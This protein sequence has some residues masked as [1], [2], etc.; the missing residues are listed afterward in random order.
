MKRQLIT[1]NTSLAKRISPHRGYQQLPI[2]SCIC[3]VKEPMSTSNKAFLTFTKTAKEAEATCQAKGI[4]LCVANSMLTLCFRCPP[5]VRKSYTSKRYSLYIWNPIK[6]KIKPLQIWIPVGQFSN[7]LFF[8]TCFTE[9]SRSECWSLVGVFK[10]PG[11]GGNLLSTQNQIWGHFGRI[12]L[13][14]VAFGM[15]SAFWSQ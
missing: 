6:S 2:H 14:Q 13:L 3:L 4:S 8:Q 9:F 1:L 7:K 10:L 12:P 11:L 5:G 15:T